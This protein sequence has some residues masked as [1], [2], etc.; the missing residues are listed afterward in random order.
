MRPVADRGERLFADM[1]FTNCSDR[2]VPFT[3]TL[4]PL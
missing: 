4:P 1:D 3:K 2:K